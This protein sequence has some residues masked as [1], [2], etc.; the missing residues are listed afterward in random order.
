[1][2]LLGVVYQ[3]LLAFLTAIIKSPECNLSAQEQSVRVCGED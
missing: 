1:M 3:E 2:S